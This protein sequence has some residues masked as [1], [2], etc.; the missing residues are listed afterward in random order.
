[1]DQRLSGLVAQHQDTLARELGLQQDHAKRSAAFVLLVLQTELGLSDED[2][3]DCI[4]EGSGDFGIDALHFEYPVEG[5]IA[6]TVVQ[7]KYGQDLEGVRAFPRE[8]GG[9]NGRCDR[10]PI[11]P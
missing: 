9:Q 10:R 11:R 5:E 3:L 6:I 8:R 2:A 7:G 1:M 4:V